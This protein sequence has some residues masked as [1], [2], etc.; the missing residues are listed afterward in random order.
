MIG[1]F[2]L[3]RLIGVLSAVVVNI[4]VYA[5]RGDQTGMTVW[6]LNAIPA[7]EL[8][9][10]RVLKRWREN[11]TEVEEDRL[12]NRIRDRLSDLDLQYRVRNHAT[13]VDLWEALQ[14]QNAAAIFWIGHANAK[15]SA[16]AGVTDALLVDAN[17]SDVS[18]LLPYASGNLR[19]LAVVACRFG[20][21][22][23]KWAADAIFQNQHPLLETKGFPTEV[24]PEWGVLR[25]AARAAA[26]LN[27]TRSIAHSLS[28]E[29][30]SPYN[31]TF[32]LESEFRENV[33]LRIKIANKVV[34]VVSAKDFGRL[35]AIMLSVPKDAQSQTITVETGSA[36]PVTG[37]QIPIISI[38]DS[39]GSLT[40][41]VLSDRKTGMPIGFTMNVFLPA[42]T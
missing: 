33:S 6:I 39:T 11:S 4:S 41:H 26:H 37:P 16:Q 3:L 34:S 27:N 28:E 2:T 9:S 7:Q 15:A 31:L 42:G 14:D 18:E 20:A 13:Q 8:S 38:T 21:S 30:H 35:G 29:R 1:R 19:Y 24:D 10:G 40:H 36:H 32:R 22:L 5:D 17:G 12:T 25:A 23:E